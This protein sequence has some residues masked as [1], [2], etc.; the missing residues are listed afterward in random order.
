MT[1]SAKLGIG[2]KVEYETT[3]GASPV[4]F[5]NFPQ[6]MDVE[7]PEQLR[8]SVETTNQDSTG[9]TREFIAGL[10]DPGEFTFEAN[11]L[12]N[13]AA[14]QA[15]RDAQQASDAGR[16]QWRIRETTS[17]PE[18]TATFTAE[19]LAFTPSAPVDDKRMVSVTLRVSG[20]VTYA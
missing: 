13:D 1:T 14:Q 19:I 7:Y 16:R 11:Y 3:P 4:A 8:E 6:V 18:I 17:S 10:I 15:I 5:T 9:F 2:T 12:P 20:P